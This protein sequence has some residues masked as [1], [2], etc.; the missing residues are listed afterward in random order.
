MSTENEVWEQF[1]EALQ[2]F[3]KEQVDLPASLATS[4]VVGF[5]AGWQVAQ[6]AMRRWPSGLS[7]FWCGRGKSEPERCPCPTG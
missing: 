5:Y 1:D 7:A 4:R 2:D 6:N 3:K